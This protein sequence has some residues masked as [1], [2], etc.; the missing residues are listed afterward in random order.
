MC[1]ASKILLKPV[2]LAIALVSPH[3]AFPAGGAT[4]DAPLFES[5][6]LPILAAKCFSCH[7]TGKRKHGLD[8]R[9][10]R[11]LLRGGHSGPASG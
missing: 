5:H 3:R 11:L 7:S 4:P 8:V 9:Q 6:V 1:P 10:R 2:I